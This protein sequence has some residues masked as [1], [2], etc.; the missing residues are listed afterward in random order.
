[1]LKPVDFFF[2]YDLCFIIIRRSTSAGAREGQIREIAALESGRHGPVLAID[3]AFVRERIFGAVHEHSLAS[4]GVPFKGREKLLF[5][6][7]R[8][9][10]ADVVCLYPPFDSWIINSVIAVTGYRAAVGDRKAVKQRPVSVEGM[11]VT[12]GK[13]FLELV[14]GGIQAVLAAH[15]RV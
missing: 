12:I 14:R 8:A 2:G 6:F 3:A 15:D 10:R 13:V 11:F 9:N 7:G 5:V 1:M 4:F